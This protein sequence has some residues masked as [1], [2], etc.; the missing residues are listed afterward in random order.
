MVELVLQ[1]YGFNKE[2]YKKEKEKLQKYLNNKVTI[3]HV[4]STTIPDM[5]GKNIL[6]VLIGVPTKQ[7]F[8]EVKEQL[9][10]IGYQINKESEEEIYQFLATTKGE[11]TEKDTHIHLALEN[12]TS[13]KEFLILRNYLLNNKDEARAYS[14]YKKELIKKGITDRKEYKR[15]KSLYVTKLINKAKG[16]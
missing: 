15:I 6:D 14:N 9:L 10:N 11:T 3:E 13:Y 4:G 12:T 5:H 16:R 1:N 7:I 2:R 8:N